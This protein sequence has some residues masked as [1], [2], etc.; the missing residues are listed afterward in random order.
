MVILHAIGVPNKAPFRLALGLQLG[1]LIAYGP[2]TTEDFHGAATYIDRI[3]K[4]AKIAD[5][6]FLAIAAAILVGIW[7]A[8]SGSNGARAIARQRRRMP[9][10]TQCT[11]AASYIR[12]S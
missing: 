10:A 11:S 3:F 12:R 1:A 9:V 5:L 6:P 2:P 4:G 8:N 7:I